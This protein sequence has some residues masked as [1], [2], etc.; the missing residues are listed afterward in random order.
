LL[1]RLLLTTGADATIPVIPLLDTIKQVH[2]DVVV[3]TVSRE[4]L[5]RSQTPQVCR[6]QALRSAHHKSSDQTDEAAAIESIGGSVRVVPGDPANLKVT[7]S[8]DLE[9]LRKLMDES[10]TIRTGIGYDIHRF[11]PGLRLVIGGIEIPEADGLA[12]HSDAD[13]LT[14]AICDAL[15]GAAGM[16]DIGVLFPNTDPAYAGIDSQNLAVDVAA[17]LAAAGWRTE[18]VDSTVVAERPKISGY[19]PAM[20]ERLAK[21]LGVQPDRVNVKATTN[22]GLGAL[23]AAEGIAAYAIATIIR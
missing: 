3:G 15:L 10:P 1:D 11:G 16:P 5:Y 18:N 22:E 9:I 23:G 17:R 19:V 7:T 20:R 8:E 21:S 13:V 2:N 12:G 14:H 6:L 4:G